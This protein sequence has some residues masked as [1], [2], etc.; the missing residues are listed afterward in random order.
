MSSPAEAKE[1]AEQELLIDKHEEGGSMT[2]MEVSLKIFLPTKK[3]DDPTTICTDDDDVPALSNS[4]SQQ[5]LSTQLLEEEVEEVEVEEERPEEG[6]EE[7]RTKKTTKSQ[8]IFVNMSH[9]NNTS[10]SASSSKL[11]KQQNSKSKLNRKKEKS[12]LKL[13]KASK[14]SASSYFVRATKHLVNKVL[15]SGT[16]KQTTSKTTDPLVTTGI[17]S[18]KKMESADPGIISIELARTFDSVDVDVDQVK[19]VD[20]D[21]EDTV[22]NHDDE[23]YDHFVRATRHLVI[24]VLRGT[25][26]QTTS[27]STDPLVTTGIPSSKKKEDDDTGIISIEL[28]R[29]FDS[30]DNVDQVEEDVDTDLED[31]VKNHDEEDYDHNHDDMSHISVKNITE[32]M[33]EQ[34]HQEQK[35]KMVVGPEGIVSFL[36]SWPFLTSLMLSLLFVE[37][38]VPPDNDEEQEQ[39][40]SSRSTAVDDISAPSSPVQRHSIHYSVHVPTD[41]NDADADAPPSPILQ[42]IKYWEEKALNDSI[43]SSSSLFNI[44]PRPPTTGRLSASQLNLFEDDDHKRDMEPLIDLDELYGHVKELKPDMEHLG[45]G[46]SADDGYNKTLPRMSAITLD[47]VT[48]SSSSSKFGE[49]RS[50]RHYRR[51]FRKSGGIHS[52]HFRETQRTIIILIICITIGISFIDYAFDYCETQSMFHMHD[53][54]TK[55]ND[56]AIVRIIVDDTNNNTLLISDGK[57]SPPSLM[58]EKQIHQQQRQ[59]YWDEHIVSTFL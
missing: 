14:K 7:P 31:T 44:P 50:T 47:S 30:V 55:T 24:K 15:S 56:T 57:S 40:Q 17:P 27:K 21:L 28:A 52:N 4:S 26:K 18:S 16:N 6:S 19:D 48:E 37:I 46:K 1:K 41:D 2:K 12:K 33:K 53:D 3:D 22:K 43:S 39:E 13:S 9:D 59:N 34:E 32:I 36:F 10:S 29:T 42:S 25:N 45:R 49:R 5:R 11:K 54:D 20:T 23:D 58:M 8:E 35:H 51:S 38:I